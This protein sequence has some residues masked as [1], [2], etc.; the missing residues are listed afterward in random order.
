MFDEKNPGFFSELIMMDVPAQVTLKSKKQLLSVL[1]YQMTL[2][3]AF[4]V[5]Q[6]VGKFLTQ[7]VMVF[8][9]HNPPYS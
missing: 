9:K 1:A 5:F 7:K 4:L 8:F 3:I 6:S 2:L